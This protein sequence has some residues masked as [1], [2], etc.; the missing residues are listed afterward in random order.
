MRESSPCSRRP[1]QNVLT[2]AE[3]ATAR[4]AVLAGEDPPATLLA[5]CRDRVALLARTAALPAHYSPYGNWNDEA[6]EEVYAD[7]VAV[8][9]VGRDQLTAMLQ[10]APLLRVFRRMVETSVRQHLVDGL[11]PSQAANLY[12]RVVGLLDK[13]DQ[14]IGVGSGTGRL[15]HIA[16]GPREPFPGDDRQLL[17]IAWSLGEFRVIRYDLDA[18]KL[19]P[20]LD[21]DDLLRFVV[22]MLQ[23]GAMTAGTIVRAIRLRFG[24]EEDQP[25][26]ELD[27]TLQATGAPDPQAAPIVAEIVTATLAELTER[28]AKV[29]MATPDVP[30]RE[31]AVQLG[32]SVGTISHERSRIADILSRLGGDAPGVLNKV[33]EALFQQNT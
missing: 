26:S 7:W 22:G 32:C 13:G 12:E 19:S 4:S 23:A 24:L 16:D 28:Q 20:L 31:V 21:A 11:K 5:D 15:W 29:L 9:G 2:E 14:F 10:R 17:G 1:A 3:Y 18:R 25:H 6:I 27:D 8:R 30:V 33:L